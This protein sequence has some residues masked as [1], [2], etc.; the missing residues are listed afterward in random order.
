VYR[1]GRA[2]VP[3]LDRDVHQHAG[4]QRPQRER[5]GLGLQRG[6]PQLDGRYLFGV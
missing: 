3:R 2:T 1:L 6:P 4:H 5:A